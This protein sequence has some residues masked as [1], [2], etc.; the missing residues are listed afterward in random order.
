VLFDRLAFLQFV[1]LPQQINQEITVDPV[2]HKTL[3]AIT[4]PDKEERPNRMKV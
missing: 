3:K 4:W 2:Y 1:P